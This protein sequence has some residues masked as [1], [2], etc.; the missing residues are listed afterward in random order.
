M[1]EPLSSGR[2]LIIVCGLPGVGKSTVASMITELTGGECLRTDDIRREVFDSPQYTPEE[3][4]V[5]YEALLDRAQALLQGTD[6]VLDGTF[7]DTSKRESAR[8]LADLTD[9]EHRFLR[10]HT[11]ERVVKER[12]SGRQA[13]RDADFRIHLEKKASFDEFSDEVP[14]IDNSGTT[15]KTRRQIEGWVREAF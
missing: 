13:P 3:S 10:V 6:I 9:A 4:R 7:S 2:T 14:V 12:I 11:D 8:R 1:S 15:A 5:T